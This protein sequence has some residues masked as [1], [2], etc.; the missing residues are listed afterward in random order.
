MP[1]I[2]PRYADPRVLRQPLECG[3][4]VIAAHCGTKSGLFDPEYFFVL[5]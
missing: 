5:L 1:V 2:E 4:K 3:V